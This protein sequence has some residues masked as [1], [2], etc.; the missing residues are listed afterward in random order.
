M[1]ANFAL[2]FSSCFAKYVQAKNCVLYG[3]T[4]GALYQPVRWIQPYDCL[5]LA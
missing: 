2:L 1:K 4:A 3:L 5:C